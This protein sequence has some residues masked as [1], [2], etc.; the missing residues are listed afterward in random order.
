MNNPKD[1]KETLIHRDLSWLSFNERVLKEAFDTS[2]PL[3]ERVKFLSIVANNLDEFFMVR[4]SGLKRLIAAGY[5]HKDAFGYYP[6][7]LFSE[8]QYRINIQIQELY[9]GYKENI[10]NALK[11]NNIFIL[12]PEQLNSEQTKAI[13]KY[14][15]ETLF[16]IVTPMAVD[17]GHPFPALHSKTIAFALQLSRNNEFYS[18]LCLIPKSVPRLF[19]LPS[20]KQESCFIFIEEILRFHLKSFFR[21]YQIIDSF[22]FRLLRDSEIS[23]EEEYAPDLLKAMEIEIG[24]RPKAK[25]ISLQVEKSKHSRLLEFLYTNLD[26][27]K[28][29][30]IFIDDSL[31][32]SSLSELTF[33]AIRPEL[34]F[35]SYT[36]AKTEYQNIF[37]K[38]KEGDF[39]LHVPYQSFSPTVDLIQTAAKDND[40]LAIKMTLYRTNEDSAI[41]K[42]LVEAAKNKKQVTV[43]VELKA[44]F[45]EERN[46][47]WTKSLELAGC[48]VIYGISGI[49]IH[50]KIALIVRQEEGRIVRYAHMA[51]GNY[52]EKTA[53]IYTDIGY[54]TRIDDFAMDISDIF[55]VITGYSQPA[56]WKKIV[57]SPND[58]RKYFFD[59]ID[60]EIQFQK[61]S[62]NGFVFAKM[63]SLEDPEIINKLYEASN[64]GVKIKLIVRG[65]CC[66]IP[67]VEGMSENIEIKSIVGRF[68]EHSRV[69]I[70]NHNGSPRTFLSSADW[71]RRNFDSRIELLFEVTRQDL[72]EHLRFILDECWKDT[73]KTRILT[74]SREYIHCLPN[75][76]MFNAQENFI[77]Y[78]AK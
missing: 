14:F 11:K 8:I 44:R 35:S 21:G 20:D 57:A 41:I 54:F 43:V 4:V 19:K 46:I 5:N 16:P 69:F 78:Y 67:G 24:K 77:K 15:E 74:S 76:K 40:V 25:V 18:A 52:N 65:I 62:N 45:D 29:D 32:L 39:L 17:S 48:H 10:N 12:K 72:N 23:I 53:R 30:I 3:F 7:E 34:M 55:N 28:D 22:L 47:E 68:L 36:P 50:S 38:I 64:S 31:D 63:N 59:L 1:P 61:K 6:T 66:L 37:D 58:M 71:M 13:K 42:A 70:F 60:K 75:E 73:A 56:R 9:N 49:K 2:N 27:P 26:F 51:T 33:K